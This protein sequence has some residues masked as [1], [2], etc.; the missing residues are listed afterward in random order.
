MAK[1]KIV[2]VELVE[3][4]GWSGGPLGSKQHGDDPFDYDV[5]TDPQQLVALGLVREVEAKAAPAK[6]D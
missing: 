3:G 4:R 1:E 5:G 2:R 6:R